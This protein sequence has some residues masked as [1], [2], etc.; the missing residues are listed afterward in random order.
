MFTFSSEQVQTLWDI[1]SSAITKFRSQDFLKQAFIG[2]PLL[3]FLAWLMSGFE[4]T[5]WTKY[6][7]AAVIM[8]FIESLI[9]ICLFFIRKDIL[10][11]ESPKKYKT[12]FLILYDV[13]SLSWL[14]WVFLEMGKNYFI[15]GP[16][17]PLLTL[18]QIQRLE[19][20]FIFSIALLGIIF[21]PTILKRKLRNNAETGSSKETTKRLSIFIGSVAGVG[22]LLSNVLDVDIGS[23]FMCISGIF[24]ISTLIFSI[25]LS[26]VEFLYFIKLRKIL[27]M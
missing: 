15:F 1:R 4:P 22:I 14:V 13:L 24:V 21:S 3:S 19:I 18:I 26:T 23:F 6:L 9:F 25:L 12:L 2:L 8:F 7:I 20:V 17:T 11:T 27:K 10:F 16:S 5:L